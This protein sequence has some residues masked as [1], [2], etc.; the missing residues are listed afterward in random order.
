MLP[1][2]LNNRGGGRM[3][4]EAAIALKRSQALLTAGK[5]LGDMQ[6]A[7]GWDSQVVG[8]PATNKLVLLPRVEAAVLEVP[9]CEAL[10]ANSD[11]LST[12]ATWLHPNPITHA[13]APHDLRLPLLRLLASLP[14]DTTLES[15]KAMLKASGIGKVVNLLAAKDPDLVCKQVAASLVQKW[16]CPVLG[17]TQDLAA[18]TAARES[19]P[20]P[21]QPTSA[22]V[23]A[24]PASACDTTRYFYEMTK[25]EQLAYL[26]AVRVKKPD[27]PV[28]D[29]TIRPAQPEVVGKKRKGSAVLSVHQRLAKQLKAYKPKPSRLHPDEEEASVRRA[30]ES[31]ARMRC[32]LARAV[33][34]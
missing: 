12:C 34:S 11:F 23:P 24:A 28:L 8:E 16:I 14:I 30:Q 29:Y 4:K 2:F 3:A 26:D 19:A 10:L 1:R 6:V 33:K 20:A 13:L 18:V 17:K 5:L 21:A 7:A 31:V 25:D 22:P 15:G 32:E 9:V 27:E